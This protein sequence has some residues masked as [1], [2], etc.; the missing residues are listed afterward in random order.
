MTYAFCVKTDDPALLILRKLYPVTLYDERY[1]KVI[2]EAGEATIYPADFFLPV[3]LPQEV[4]TKL[5]QIA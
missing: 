5:A 2:D 3:S 1:V 4:T